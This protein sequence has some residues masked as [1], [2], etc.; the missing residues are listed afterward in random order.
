MVAAQLSMDIRRDRSSSTVEPFL[1]LP[2]FSH[3]ALHNLG[4]LSGLT[5]QATPSELIL[6]LHLSFFSNTFN[7]Y[8]TMQSSDTASAAHI[9]PCPPANTPPSSPC[10]SPVS[11]IVTR[12]LPASPTLLHLNENVTVKLLRKTFLE[13]I[14]AVQKS[15]VSAES[16]SPLASPPETVK[17]AQSRKRASKLEV[18]SILE[19]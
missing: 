14:K 13:T 18:K 17:T 16:S 7:F 10:H 2:P 11:Q 1:C 6:H 9:S 19:M 15:V 3:L 4:Q 12:T 8:Q 5:A